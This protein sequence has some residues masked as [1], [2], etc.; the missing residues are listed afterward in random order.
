MKQETSRSIIIEKEIPTHLG[1][2]QLI[3]I[4]FKENK[5]YSDLSEYKIRVFSQTIL[6][7]CKGR[8]KQHDEK[9]VLS[10]YVCFNG[11]FFIKV[12]EYNIFM[13]LIK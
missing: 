1:L 11:F 5:K 12:K 13:I 8:L 10:F 7:H 2:Y 4:L 6:G 3:I 9:Y